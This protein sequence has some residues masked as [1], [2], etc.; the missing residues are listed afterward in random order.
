ML[1]MQKGQ[2]YLVEYA[3]FF[4]QKLLARA[5]LTLDQPIK[6]S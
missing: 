4:L 3:L 1:L 5:Y 6:T 2:S